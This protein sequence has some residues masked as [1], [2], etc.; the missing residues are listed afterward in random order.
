ML[1]YYFLSIYSLLENFPDLKFFC[2]ILV[3]ECL[4]SPDFPDCK[5]FKICPDFPDRWE[6][7]CGIQAF[8]T[9]PISPMS[10]PGVLLSASFDLL[11]FPG[12]GD[13][14]LAVVLKTKSKI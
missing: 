1:F 8:D 7:C 11:R 3:E 2:L 13:F 12:R 9:L 4:F 10:S 6:P 14:A 5:V